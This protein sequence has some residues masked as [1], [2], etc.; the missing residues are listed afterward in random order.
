MHAL[1]EK[2]RKMPRNKPELFS[3]LYYVGGDIQRITDRDGTIV[4]DAKITPNQAKN[5][6]I[7]DRPME[8]SVLRFW[9][10]SDVD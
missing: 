1:F 2:I 3:S 9:P 4:V 10:E 6:G 7:P 5:M 8:T